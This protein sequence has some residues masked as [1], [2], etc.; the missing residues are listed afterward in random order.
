MALKIM[1]SN[2]NINFYNYNKYVTTNY[3]YY[4]RMS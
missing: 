2:L 3:A 4:C 1:A